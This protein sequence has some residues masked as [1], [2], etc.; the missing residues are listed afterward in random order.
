[1]RCGIGM[2]HQHFK[3]IDVLSAAENMVLGMK[4]QPESETDDAEKIRRHL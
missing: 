3:L 2:V 4:G 1:M